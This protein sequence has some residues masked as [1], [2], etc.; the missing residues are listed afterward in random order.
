MPCRQHGIFTC[1]NTHALER[2]S[3]RAASASVWSNDSNAPRAVRYIS[4]KLTTTVANTAAY[5]TMVRRAPSAESAHAPRGRRGPRS[6]S[7]RKPTTVGGST[8][9]SVS[10]TSASPHT[11]R[12]ARDT[13][14][15]RAMPRRNTTTV[16]AAATLSEFARGKRSMSFS[17][18]PWQAR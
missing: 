5:H 10:T 13:T 16:E 1:Q 6:I 4:G 14:F 15:A 12:G 9:G 11:T 8:S 3:V 2:P 17:P 18:R 7:S